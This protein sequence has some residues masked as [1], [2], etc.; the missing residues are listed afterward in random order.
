MDLQIWVGEGMWSYKPSQLIKFNSLLILKILISHISLFLELS[1]PWLGVGEWRHTLPWMSRAHCGTS[2]QEKAFSWIIFKGNHQP[3]SHNRLKTEPEM[4]VCAFG[5]PPFRLMLK[6]CS[7]VNPGHWTN[8]GLLSELPPP[9][10]TGGQPRAVGSWWLLGDRGISCS[11][12]GV[13]LFP[14]GYLLRGPRVR[15]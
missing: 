14:S 13:V 1:K 10:H 12:I 11:P 7:H 9:A 2:L 6:A 5:S 8:T 3:H 15:R 4:A